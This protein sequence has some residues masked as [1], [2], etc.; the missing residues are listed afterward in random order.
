MLRAEQREPLP[1]S[2]R[3]TR[4]SG[5]SCGRR[6]RRAS[7]G[8]R[9][10]AGPCSCRSRSCPRSSST[11]V[12]IAN[13]LLDNL[14]FGVA[15]CDGTTLAGG[16]D[17]APGR[18]VLRGARARA[19]HRRGRAPRDRGR[20]RG[21]ARRPPPDPARHRR[22]VR[23][24]AAACCATA[25]SWSSTTSTT[26]RAWSGGAQRP[27]LRTYRSHERRNCTRSTHPASRTSP[28][29]SCASS[30]SAPRRGRVHRRGRRVAGGVAPRS[31]HRGPRRRGPPALG[32]AR[33]HRRPRGAGGPQP[34][35]RRPPRS[36]TPP[37]SVATAS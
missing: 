28:P 8:R 37:A 16:A 35:R 36:P 15:E 23:G 27:W 7:R 33:A 9:Q 13:E 32:G 17:R 10:S 25:R 11:G 20:P 3:P 12:V 22:V 30:S 6:R 34:R 29:T 2:N 4:R 21:R 5:R 14:P 26:R 19:G 31:R 24:D 18:R 1:I